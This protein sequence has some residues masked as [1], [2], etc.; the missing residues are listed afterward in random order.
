[1][2]TKVSLTRSQDPANYPN[3]EPRSA[4]SPK[5]SFLMISFIIILPSMLRLSKSC[6]S[7][8]FPYQFPVCITHLPHAC[9]MSR[10]SHSSGLDQTKN[11]KVCSSR[12]FCLCSLFNSSLNSSILGPN[13]WVDNLLTF[14]RL[15]TYMYVIPHRKPPDVAFYIFIQQ[16][17]VLNILNMLHTLRFFLFKMPF[18]S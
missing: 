11:Y 6:L 8:R 3:P 4:H 10:P 14:S 12:S 17:Y 9:H 7:I 15:M 18:I 13:T 1:M 5:H 16:I 2:E